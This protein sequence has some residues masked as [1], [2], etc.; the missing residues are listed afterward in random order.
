[1]DLRQRKVLGLGAVSDLFG[2]G[3]PAFS[4]AS[5]LFDEIA[6]ARGQEEAETIFTTI[7]EFWKRKRKRGR[8]RP[9]GAPKVR[10]QDAQLLTTA[11]IMRSQNPKARDTDI[12]RK[13]LFIVERK[14]SPSA[15]AVGKAARA[16]GRAR[17]R[18]VLKT[19]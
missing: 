13:Y 12:A 1:M 3:D 2:G 19:K 8:G 4:R 16:L 6:E 15:E 14:K 11:Q 7:V 5:Q 18:A 10:L 17:K 9:K